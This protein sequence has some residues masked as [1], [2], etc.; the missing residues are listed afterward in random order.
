MKKAKKVYK[1][2]VKAKS[3]TLEDM[4]KAAHAVGAK[5]S[6]SLLPKQPPRPLLQLPS[7]QWP[8]T[9]GTRSIMAALDYTENDVKR[10]FL[11][12]PSSQWIITPYEVIERRVF[13]APKPVPEPVAQPEQPASN[14]S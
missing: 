8:G 14:P 1:R 2:R 10:V 12:N 7:G 11:D 9:P 4:V 13:F 3:P 5:F 6:V